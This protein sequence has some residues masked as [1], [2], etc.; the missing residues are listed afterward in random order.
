MSG[1]E[2]I[3]YAQWGVDFFHEAISEERVVNAVNTIAGQHIDIEP[4]GVGPGGI[5]KMTAHGKVGLATADRMPGEIIS[6]RAMVPVDLTFEVD[7]KVEKQRFDAQLVVP[8]TLTAVARSGLGI[9]IAAA[10]PATH[11]VEVHLRAQGRRGSFLQRVAG[12]EDELRRFVADYVSGELERPE[13]RRTRTI[14]VSRAIPDVWASIGP[15]TDASAA[16]DEA[17][18]AGAEAP[19]EVG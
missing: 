18:E 16:L 10:P 2:P 6:F 11:E 4:V 7:L 8:L 1:G 5:A 3:S 19:G 9:F 13:V 12:I 15:E 17:A 14:D